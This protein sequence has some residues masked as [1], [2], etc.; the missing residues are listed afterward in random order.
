MIDEFKNKEI[1]T[2]NHEWILVKNHYN[3]LKNIIY[4]LYINI[5]TKTEIEYIGFPIYIH[6]AIYPDEIK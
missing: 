5:V 6:G 4:F 1:F 2:I 3:K